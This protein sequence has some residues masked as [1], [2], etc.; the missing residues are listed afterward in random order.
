MTKKQQTTEDNKPKLVDFDPATL[1]KAASDKKTEAIRY[2]SI[3]TFGFGKEE[4]AAEGRFIFKPE[5]ELAGYYLRS[6][7]VRSPKLENGEGWLH[8]LKGADGTPFGIWGTG[9]LDKVMPRAEVNQYL[10][11][12]Y[13]GKIDA[14]V[15]VN[16]KLV[17]R[18]VH[19][20]EY[21]TEGGA[22]L[23]APVSQA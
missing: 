22:P 17:N 23:R 21:E 5:M 16:G 14:E 6:E 4:N 18:Q 12:R 20:F 9:S 13:K 15:E 2:E 3:P 10:L 19:S 11:I 8:V 7:L 1:G